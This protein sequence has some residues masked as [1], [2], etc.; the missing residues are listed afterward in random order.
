MGLAPH[1]L[2]TKLGLCCAKL[3]LTVDR[4][5]R[6]Q[7]LGRGR[8]GQA[9]RSASATLERAVDG[10]GVDDE[11]HAR[12]GKASEEVGWQHVALEP[13]AAAARSDE[14]AR[15]VCAAF[16]ERVHV[17]EGSDIELEGSG[18][19]HAAAAAVT[20]RGALDRSFLRVWIQS[21]GVASDAGDAWK[22]DAV[23]VSTPGQE[24]L[25]EKAT[26]RD[27]KA[28]HGGVS[29]KTRNQSGGDGTTCGALAL[30]SRDPNLV[31]GSLSS[32]SS[33]IERIVAARR[34]YQCSTRVGDAR[35]RRT[36]ASGDGLNML[37]FFHDRAAST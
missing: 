5:K 18:A 24:H 11:V 34:T 21:P 31:L 30:A 4:A 6:G 28:S 13:V 9:H 1:A 22:G 3:R 16:R 7:P 14:V 8:I 23:T 36:F 29:H 12:P 2:P 35:G 10:T 26:P 37:L 33:V 17:V 20:H 27:G 19:I 25:A 15:D 32:S